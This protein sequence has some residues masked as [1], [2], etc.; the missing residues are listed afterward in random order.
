MPARAPQVQFTVVAADVDGDAAPVQPDE[1]PRGLESERHHGPVH[2]DARLRPGGRLHPELRGHRPR[3]PDRHDERRPRRC[4]RRPAAGGGHPQPSGGS[5]ACRSSSPSRPPTS[6]PA[7]PSAIRPST[8]PSGATINPSTG[9]FSWTP[10]PS[11]AGD[12]VVTLQVSDG[13]AT[14]T[15][16]ILIVASVQP[17]LPSV[18]I[19]LTPSFPAIPGQQVRD[20]RDRQQRRADRRA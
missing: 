17:Q 9:E 2:L 18:T 3:R 12:Y 10:G 1:S 8:C 5:S 4:P 13:Q 6:T 11:Q 14:S 16:N 7:R 19:V 15:Q 20:Q